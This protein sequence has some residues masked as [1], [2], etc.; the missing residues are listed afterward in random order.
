MAVVGDAVAAGL[1]SNLARPEGNVTGSTFFD[2]EL[3]AKRLELLKEL[4]PSTSRVAVLLYSETAINEFVIQAMQATAK[5]LGMELKAFHVRGPDE[6]ESVIAD[7]AN[8]KHDG[9]VI[10]DDPSLIVN[11]RE[12]AVLATRHHLASIGLPPFS[13]AGGLMAYGV[14]HRAYMR[15]R[16]NVLHFSLAARSQSARLLEL[17][18]S[19][20]SGA[21]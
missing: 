18:Q 6:F 10:H 5:P 20:F 3:M 21:T 2:L 7:I 19:L 17:S 1:V 11:I 4:A 12:I 9:L 14:N 16:P 13:V 8:R 15:L